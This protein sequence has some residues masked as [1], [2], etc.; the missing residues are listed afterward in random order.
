[1]RAGV[2]AFTAVALLASCGG[3]SEESTPSGASRQTIE[4]GE[5]EFAL[6]PAT[7]KLD[8]SGVYT[9]R[10]ANNGSVTHALELEGEG[11][12][13]ETE[14]I[15]PGASADLKVELKPG[16]YELY[17]PIGNHEQQGMKGS[18]TVAGGAA[19][20]G[21]ATTDEDEDKGGSPY[22]Y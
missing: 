3:A 18:V 13:A 11:V 14:D 20:G 21:A 9:F 15:A 6:D 4:I 12:E 8:E 1:M 2:I 7:V 16:T 19:G 22:S 17:C 5:T 10:A